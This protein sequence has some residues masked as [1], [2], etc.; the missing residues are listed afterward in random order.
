MPDQILAHN[1]A[2]LLD[3][4]RA[5]GAATAVIRY[6]GY[7]DE[8]NANETSIVTATGESLRGDQTVTVV[9]EDSRYV[10]DQWQSAQMA[11]VISL[12]DALDAFADRA[13]ALHHP[14]F[15]NNDGGEGEITFDCAAGTVCMAH[16]DYY[17]ESCCTDTDL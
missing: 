14:G 17:V 1:R 8:G 15:E 4:L 11:A 9:C 12:R 5:A 10:N 6:S 7:G 16:R 2:V 13:V 3:A